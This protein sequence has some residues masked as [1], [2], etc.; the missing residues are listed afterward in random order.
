[1]SRQSSKSSKQRSRTDPERSTASSGNTQTL[2]SYFAAP[3]SPYISPYSPSTTQPTRTIIAPQPTSSFDF[4]S[5]TREASAIGIRTSS[6]A[7]STYSSSSQDSIYSSPGPQQYRVVTPGMMNN[8]GSLSTVSTDNFSKLLRYT[9]T[10]AP[11]I[12][13]NLYCLWEDHLSMR[14]TQSAGRGF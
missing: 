9:Y 10:A 12:S 4:T 2:S 6:A 13:Q 3:S 1:M 5:L 8:P 11:N 14:T 7:M